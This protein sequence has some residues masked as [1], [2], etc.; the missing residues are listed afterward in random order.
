MENFQSFES[1]FSGLTDAGGLCASQAK[2]SK[3]GSCGFV[4]KGIRMKVVD[5]ETGKAVGPNKR[6][7]LCIK[8]EFL[9]KCYHKNPEETKNAIDSNG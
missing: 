7:E 4:T 3:P 8:S 6:G 1:I 2:N 5:E 9:L